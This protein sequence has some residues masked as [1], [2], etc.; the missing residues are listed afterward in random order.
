MKLVMVDDAAAAALAATTQWN[1]KEL[2]DGAETPETHTHT[3]DRINC[4][5]GALIVVHLKSCVA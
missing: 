5:N 1:T 2:P 4:L 3:H